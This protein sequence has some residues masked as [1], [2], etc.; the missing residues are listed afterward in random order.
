M[1][2]PDKQAL[3]IVFASSVGFAA[4]DLN[5]VENDFLLRRQRV[6]IEP[7]GAHIIRKLLCPL[8]KQEIDAGF[9]EFHRTVNE[10]FSRQH[11]LA[12]ACSFDN[13]SR[14]S[15]RQASLSNLIQSLDAGLC[16]LNRRVFCKYFFWPSPHF[17]P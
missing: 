8:L 16:L 11:G 4:L 2:K 17:V 6:E 5:V 15:R 3:E 14:A 7:N 13:N 10:E 9:I 12:G 1:G